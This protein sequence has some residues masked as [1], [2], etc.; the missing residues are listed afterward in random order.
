MEKHRQD[1]S[2]R[3][4]QHMLARE[5]VELIHGPEASQ[6]AEAEHRQIFKLKS[7]SRAQSNATATPENGSIGDWNPGGGDKY[8]P[9]TNAFKMPSPNATL[10]RS[11]VYNQPIHKVLWSAGLVSSRSEA[12]RLVVNNGASVGSRADH[13]GN[14]SDDLAFT[15]IKTWEGKDTNKFIIDGNLIILRIGKWKLKI[16]RIISD[17]E[18]EDRGLTA[19]GWKEEE[20]VKEAGLKD[21]VRKVAKS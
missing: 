19:P 10:P 21:R 1:P 3:V 8:A 15:P 20:Q 12:H 7:S 9:K 5:F 18:F 11:L 13:K 6:N 14:M 2:K 17:E 4:A 16:V